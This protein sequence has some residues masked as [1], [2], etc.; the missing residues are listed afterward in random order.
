MRRLYIMFFG[1]FCVF[2]PVFSEDGL[3]SEEIEGE[4]RK[5]GKIQRTFYKEEF[6]P[7]LTPNAS[8]SQTLR[9]NFLE[10]KTPSFVCESLYLVKKAD[11]NRSSVALRS[12]STLKGIEYYSHSRKKMR[13]LYSECYAVDEKKKPIPDPVEGN[14][15]GKT[16]NVMMHDS[17]FGKHFYEYKFYERENQ[18]AFESKNKDT[19]FLAII[20]VL[21]A[22]K[23]TV[24]F[25]AVDM[26][27]DVLLYVLFGAD[28]FATKSMENTLTAS[29]L[30]R[31]NVLYDWFERQIK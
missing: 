4:L 28:F 5:K 22:E 10:R 27:D 23:M 12:F 24:S 13:T 8:L 2:S 30:A 9:D 15:D 25:S 16:F 18:V 11:F 17:T 19:F 20:K 29:F 26:G 1:F 6:E 7:T 31:I 21:G 3:I 14:C